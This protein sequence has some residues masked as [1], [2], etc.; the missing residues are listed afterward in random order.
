MQNSDFEKAVAI[1][2]SEFGD[3][4]RYIVQTLGTE[5][6]RNRVGKELTSFI[7]YPRRQE[8]GEN[9]WRGNCAP[10][11][12]AD[13][14]KYVLEYKRY[15]KKDVSDFT[16]LDPMSGSGTSKAVA[17]SFNVRSVLY[18]LNPNPNQGIGNWNALK[19]DVEDS[20]DL[21]L[22]HPPYHSI[23][24]YSGKVWG[25]QAHPDDLSRCASYKEFIEKLN[26]VIKKLYVAL[27]PDGRLAVLVGDFRT[28][29]AFYS[30]QSDMMKIGTFESFI[31]KAQYNCNS[32]T[33]RYST[34]FIPIVT[35][36]MLIFRKDHIFLVPYSVPY[37][38]ETDLSQTDSKA[39]T[40]HHLIRLTIENAG[41][42]ASLSDLYSLLEKH[43]KAQKNQHFKERIRA[44]IYEHPNEYTP[45]GDSGYV[46]LA[47][48]KLSSVS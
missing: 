1:L 35:E 40:W 18:D 3:D 43:P 23:I 19:N 44:T 32:D 22:F 47:Y 30:I 28:N 16:L 26:F 24:Q 12:I 33:K 34:P 5:D 4:W 45:C 14:L 7:A 11:V 41:G 9:S 39:L 37:W 6:L 36:Y 15:H 29:G 20:A 25:N 17:D 13:L 27:K 31:C 48:Q 2:K 10:Q 46:S 38:K 8:G 21:C 42:Q